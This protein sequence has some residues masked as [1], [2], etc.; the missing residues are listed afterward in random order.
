MDEVREMD[1]LGSVIDNEGSTK[2][3]IH[4]RLAKGSRCFYKHLG[5]LTNPAGRMMDRLKAFYRAVPT[6]VLHGS[7][8][9]A[10]TADLCNQLNGWE[11]NLV[12]KVAR[13]KRPAKM[14]PTKW[15]WHS[16]KL[17]K[18]WRF[19]WA[20]PRLPTERSLASTDGR[21]G[22][23]IRRAGAVS[24]TRRCGTCRTTAP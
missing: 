8:S 6:C 21:G 17:Q 22:S 20:N 4:H 24:L 11:S 1:V 15:R 12:R 16:N 3:T 14:G 9:W 7:E 10:L 5:A 13:L 18:K 2:V 23:D 19:F